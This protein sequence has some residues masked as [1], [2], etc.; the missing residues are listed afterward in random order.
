MNIPYKRDPVNEDILGSFLRF[1]QNSKHSCKSSFIFLSYT[2]QSNLDRKLS[3][4]LIDLSGSYIIFN[5]KYPEPD[6]FGIFI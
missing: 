1:Y 2:I 6:E 5:A 4:Y 3:G